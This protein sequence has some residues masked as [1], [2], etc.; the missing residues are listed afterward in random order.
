M[1]SYPSTESTSIPFSKVW[2]PNIRFRYETSKK[3]TAR[4]HPILSHHPSFLHHLNCTL[5]NKN[6]IV[7]KKPIGFT[8]N[9]SSF[10]QN[11]CQHEAHS[12][13]RPI[14]L[15]LMDTS[16]SAG[17]FRDSINNLAVTKVEKIYLGIFED[18][19]GKKAIC[20]YDWKGC[21]RP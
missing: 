19:I 10:F 16:L 21:T 3:I 18:K 1:S 11:P 17:C 20:P 12:F 7:S 5:H 4:T 2:P 9:F 15:L 14:P 8:S 13:L 6:I